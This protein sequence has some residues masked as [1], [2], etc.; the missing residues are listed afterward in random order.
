MRVTEK[1]QVTIPKEIRDRL[2]I[3]PGSDVAFVVA[4]EGV[5]LVK[6]SDAK[7]A[8]KDFDAWAESDRV[9]TSTVIDTNALIDVLGPASATRTWSLEAMKQ[10]FNE[11]ALVINPVIWSELAASRLSEQQ[12]SMALD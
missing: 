6:N 12:L 8:F 5:M 1:G 4:A 7:D 2:G 11:G 9:M 10:C 3:K